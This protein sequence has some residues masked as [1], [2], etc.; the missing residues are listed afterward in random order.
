MFGLY[1][2][3]GE[4]REA[5]VLAMSAVGTLDTSQPVL[6]GRD[7]AS[8]IIRDRLQVLPRAQE[9]ARE[10][11]VALGPGRQAAFGQIAAA[12]AAAVQV[13]DMAMAGQLACRVAGGFAEQG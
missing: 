8:A 7:D 13:D 5:A 12:V 3:E 10:V 1:S 6:T 11:G 4:E 9:H 2:N